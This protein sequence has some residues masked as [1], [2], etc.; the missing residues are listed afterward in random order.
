MSIKTIVVAST[1]PVKAQ[2]V[3]N[4]FN[5]MFPQDE[6]QVRLV[7][8]PSGVSYQPMTD[9]ETL[10]GASNRT[11]NAF[12]ATP[13]ADFWVGVEGGIQEEGD[14]MMA[15]AWIVVK[16][17]ELEGKSRSGSFQLPR[18]IVALIRQGVEL[19]EADDRLF[20]RSNSKQGNGAIGILTNDVIDRTMLYE[21]AVILALTPFIKKDLYLSKGEQNSC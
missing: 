3:L 14:Q 1:N 5:R 16:S 7:A 18:P 9:E 13:E 20:G 10:I 12:Y 21:H 2:A 4:G 11:L 8:V 6:F 19:G 15:F 17:N